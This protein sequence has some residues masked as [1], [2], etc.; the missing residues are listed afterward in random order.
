MLPI[1]VRLSALG[2]G[3]MSSPQDSFDPIGVVVDWLDACRAR[4][5]WALVDLYDDEAAVECCQR[6]L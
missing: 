1:F 4:R 6:G 5:L 3:R 2:G